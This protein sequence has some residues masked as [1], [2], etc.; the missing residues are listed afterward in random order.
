[1]SRTSLATWLAFVLLGTSALASAQDAAPL[2]REE[3]A[4]PPETAPEPDRRGEP[5]QS[6]NQPDDPSDLEQGES[7][8]PLEP[9]ASHGQSEPEQNETQSGEEPTPDSDEQPAPNTPSE[10]EPTSELDEFSALL[11]SDD[12]L[13]IPD[14][15]V[16]A[17]AE[18]EPEIDTGGTVYRLGEEE[19]ERF[20]YDD[21][22]TVLQQVPGVYVQQEDGYGL[23][24]NIGLRGVSANRS[25][26]ITLL[27]DGV[28]FAPAAYAAPAAYYFPL[29]TRMV[30]ADVYLGAATIPFGP[31][32]VGGAIDLQ[33]RDIPRELRG[34][35]DV[36]LGT[37]WLGRAHAHVG[38]SNSWGGFLVE[39]VYLHSDGYKHI[40][41]PEGENAGQ[42][43]GFDRGEIL[44]RGQLHGALG[45][46]T[47][48]RLE[49]RLGFSGEVSNE[50]YLGLTD[51]D[52]Q[53]DPY[54]R[55]EATRLDRMAW[56]RTQAQLR[57]T[58]E[59]GDDFTLRTIAY[60]HDLDRAWTKLNAMG[61][62]PTAGGA[63]SR[64]N[65]Y[66]VLE[67][68]V[69]QNAVLLSVLRGE[70][71]STGSGRDYLL[72]GTNARRFANTGIQSD[73]VGRFETAPFRHQVRGGLRLHHDAVDRHHDED[74]YAMIAA[75]TPTLERLTDDSYTTLRSHVEA[76]A[77]SGYLAWAVS[78]ETLT[79]TPGVRTELIWNRFSQEGA[80]ES[81]DFRAAFL[82]GAS[83]EWAI[84]P[85]VRL[86]G[87]VMRGFSPVAPGQAQHVRPE[88]S[89][90][91]EAGVRG[92]HTET[93]T[94]AQLTVFVNDYSNFL[95]ECSFAAGCAED[96]VDVQ[97]N[98]GEALI[99]GVDVRVQTDL[100]IDEVKIPLRASY[101]FTHAELQSVIENSPNPQFAGGQPGDR[102]PYIPEHQL[103]VQ[104]GVEMRDFGVN[105]AASYVGEMWEAVGSGDEPIPVPRTD[106]M[107]L[108]DA[109]AYVQLFEGVRLYVRGENL[110]L[111]KAIVSRHP[112][113]A[114]PNRPLLVQGGLQ[115][116][117]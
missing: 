1:M 62:L 108:L 5:E 109:T 76:L 92:T 40:G 2:E 47:Y 103:S 98:A 56:W 86:F 15:V 55:Y 31:R 96:V 107:F 101:T 110:T 36:A 17:A 58:L 33:N 89:V 91:Y 79:L 102:L 28:L 67:S 68:P 64:V 52:F 116:S 87:G 74:V 50:T 46:N 65:L 10:T 90:T 20:N 34:G 104:A 25:S 19:L 114:R 39:G 69:G 30:G 88:E 22:T 29:I 26:R 23:R 113:G 61:G 97:E 71:S 54:L 57:H 72:I 83:I 60:R 27:E 44:L 11:D 3:G 100:R 14:V 45:D 32:T 9:S 84:L 16:R 78:W 37:N 18:P 4:P 105:V 75:A 38:T 66:N 49:L 80:G 112:Y 115:L 24:P 63:Q 106:A 48:H 51:E 43:T 35:V 94:T 77:L 81:H 42:S 12:D 82:P 13:A 73:A 117:L 7:E 99:A 6:E 93:R 95:Q 53:A 70:E 59:V 111:T 41:D 85:E 21:P 8:T